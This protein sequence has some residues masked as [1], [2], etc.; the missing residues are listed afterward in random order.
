M[1]PQSLYR[2]HHAFVSAKFTRGLT[3]KEVRAWRS[4]LR[5]MDD[6]DMR[7]TNAAERRHRRRM[8]KYRKGTG[9]IVKAILQSSKRNKRIQKAARRL[10]W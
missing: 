6:Y 1:I 5:R 3:K 10:L 2:R 7:D 9:R 8:R 4:L